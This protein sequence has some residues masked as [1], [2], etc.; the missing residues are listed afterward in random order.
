MS[1]VKLGGERP[2]KKGGALERESG[3][4]QRASESRDGETKY[5]RESEE[6]VVDVAALVNAAPSQRQQQRQQH[7]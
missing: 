6:G 5:D 7:E 4:R 1:V 3:R 2:R